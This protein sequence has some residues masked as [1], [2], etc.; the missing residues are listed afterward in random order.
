MVRSL[1]TD[2]GTEWNS[3]SLEL[4]SSHV[5]PSALQTHQVDGQVAPSLT[6]RSLESLITM[7]AVT[8]TLKNHVRTSLQGPSGSSAKGTRLQKT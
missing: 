5:F 7:Q 2:L 6:L 1:H 8:G 3:S 4:S